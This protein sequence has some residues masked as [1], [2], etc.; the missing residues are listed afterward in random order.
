M[1]ELFLRVFDTVPFDRRN[2]LLTL[3]QLPTTPPRIKLM[4]CDDED[5]VTLVFDEKEQVDKFVDELLV[6]RQRVFPDD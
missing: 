4:L 2:G 1:F 5:E 3:I 6:L